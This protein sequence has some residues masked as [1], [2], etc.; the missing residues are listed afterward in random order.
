M[1]TTVELLKVNPTIG[2]LQR[3]RMDGSLSFLRGRHCLRML[4]TLVTDLVDATKLDRK[5]NE[6]A[7]STRYLLGESLYQRM[8]KVSEV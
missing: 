7:C 2:D 8:E 4:T 1:I 3:K 5:S 6:N